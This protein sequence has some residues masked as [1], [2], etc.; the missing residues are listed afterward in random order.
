MTRAL[1]DSIDAMLDP[2]TLGEIEG[3]PAP[4]VRRLPFHSDDSLS[5]SRFLAVETDGEAGRRYV[6]KRLAREWDWLMRVT[7]DERGRPIVAWQ[8]GLLDRLPPEIVHGVVA[9]A[10][11]GDGW[12]ILMRDFSGHLIPPGDEPIAAADNER[13]LA[14]MAAMH[15]AFWETPR[16]ADPALGFCDLEHHYLE[17]SPAVVRREVGTHPIPGHVVDGWALL[18]DLLSPAVV[19]VLQPLLADPT[20]LCDALRRYPQTVIHGD[21]KLG[22]LGLLPAP[23]RQVVLLDWAVVGPAPPAVDLA[24]WL[25]V[26]SARLP[27]SKEATTAIFR[28]HLAARLGP[29][30]DEAW[31]RPQLA[32][33]LLGGF[34]QLGWPKLLGAAHGP[35]EAVRA[36]ERAELAWWSE[37]VLAGALHL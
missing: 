23:G 2:A 3:R 33:G 16:V 8:T 18:P 22:N 6:V 37:R 19:A 28:D 4:A 21:W 20:P 31:W 35:I 17:F 24:W 25:A 11:D 10:R 34:L 13:F 30:F 7:G 36:R 26:N 14:A 1:F 9:C 27:I 12:A 32:L 15:A 5:G 29:R